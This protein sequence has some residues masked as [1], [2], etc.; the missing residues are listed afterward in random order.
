M[1][2]F[3]IALAAAGLA[4]SL[5]AYA[6]VPTDAQPFQ[7]VVPNLK[8]GIEITL[9]GL[10]LR[11]T[12]DNQ[13]YA[14]TSDFAFATT[15]GNI[16]PITTTN[17]KSLSQ[18]NPDYNF[19]FRVG[20]GYIFPDSGN[21]V[22]LNW[23]HFNHSDDTST[24][25]NDAGEVLTTGFGVPLINLGNGVTTPGFL[26]DPLTF[27]NLVGGAPAASSSSDFKYDQ[28]NLDV[29][30]YLD[31]GTRLRL[32][33]F[34]G[35][36]YA[37]VEN[38]LS[39][40]YFAGYNVSSATDVEDPID[41]DATY[42]EN[43]TLDSKFTGIGPRFG[44]DS[45]YHIANCFGFVAHVAGALYVGKVDSSTNQNITITALDNNA[46]PG[47][48][49]ATVTDVLD[50]SINTTT[51]NQWRVVP[52]FDAKLGLDYTYIAQNQS[53]FS[54]EA[55]YQW[56]QYIDAVDRLNNTALGGVYKTT[57]SVGFDG[58]YLTLN[59]KM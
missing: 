58:P 21:D 37:R 59:Y 48:T 9:E 2:K 53:M 36:S 25:T 8:S 46:D 32:R 5:G 20:L 50:S 57:S 34:G 45:S 31:V 14:T 47:D 4:A 38:N 16:V 52:A 44:V 43:D 22:Q 1:K 17:A 41:F 27:S 33:M 51:D 10:L 3:S 29:G 49:F 28:V 13:Q 7:L 24:T 54:I 55:G 26:I 15:P 11:P 40:S 19:G 6:A 18:A 42:A 39:N 30:Q 35:L 12:N 56:T 23:V